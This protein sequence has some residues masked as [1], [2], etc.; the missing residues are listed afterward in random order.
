LHFNALGLDLHF[1]ASGKRNRLS[2]Y[3]RHIFLP[4]LAK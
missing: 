3:A 1:D 4:D 2:A